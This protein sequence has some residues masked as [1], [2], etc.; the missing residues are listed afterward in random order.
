LIDSTAGVKVKR[1]LPEDLRETTALA[2]ETAFSASGEGEFPF[3]ITI[4]MS[5]V[6]LV[7]YEYAIMLVEIDR[8][9]L[10]VEI[11]R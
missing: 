5:K 11:R 2:P 9:N 8:D 7:F 4:V 10:G 6:G 3:Q 1:A